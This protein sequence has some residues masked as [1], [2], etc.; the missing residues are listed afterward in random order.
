VLKLMS[1]LQER[2]NQKEIKELGRAK[3]EQQAKYI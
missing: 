3:E 2:E 1:Q